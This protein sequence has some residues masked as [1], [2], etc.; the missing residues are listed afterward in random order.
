MAKEKKLD[1][2]QKESLGSWM[3]ETLKL[4][5][6][7]EDPDLLNEY[8]KIFKRNVP[9]HLRAYFAAY[10]I[11][12]QNNSTKIKSFTKSKPAPEKADPKQNNSD[13][14]SLFFGMG[15][16]R[17]V[18]PQDIIQ[19]IVSRSGAS[20]D[21]IL[22][23]KILDNYSFVEVNGDKA[24]MIIEKFKGYEYKGKKVTVNFARKKN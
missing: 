21:D 22:S 4:I 7:E 5:K 3:K 19:I 23:V 10:L 9:I 6:Y 2:N 16:N 24:S 14:A 11:K 12:A 8:R 15:K 18:F 17:R 1:D 20:K 13:S